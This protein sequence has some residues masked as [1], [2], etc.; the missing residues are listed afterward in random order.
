[1]GSYILFFRTPWCRNLRN[2]RY[3]VA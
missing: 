3:Y 2:V 1:M